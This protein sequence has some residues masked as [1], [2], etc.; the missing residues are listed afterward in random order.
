MTLLNVVEGSIIRVH[1]RMKAAD[2]VF[3]AKVTSIEWCETTLPQTGAGWRIGYVPCDR[4]DS[5]QCGFGYTYFSYARP[6]QWGVQH[7][8]VVG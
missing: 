3:T 2:V 6:Q 5:I 4:P 1:K 8:E 7:I